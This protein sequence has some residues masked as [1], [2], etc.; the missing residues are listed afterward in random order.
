MCLR[1]ETPKKVLLV[2]LLFYFIQNA[3]L[4]VSLKNVC[5]KY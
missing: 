2:Y 1:S 4:N 5:A 3:G